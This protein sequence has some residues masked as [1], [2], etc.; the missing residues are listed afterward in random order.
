MEFRWGN[1]W[2]TV[3]NYT[4]AKDPKKAL[5]YIDELERAYIKRRGPKGDFPTP[6]AFRRYA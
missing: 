2:R 1:A 5:A 6:S 3:A 4:T